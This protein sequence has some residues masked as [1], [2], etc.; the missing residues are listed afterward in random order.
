MNGQRVEVAQIAGA[1]L[2]DRLVSG[3]PLVGALYG[4]SPGALES[5]RAKL[6]EVGVRFDRAARERAAAALRPTSERAAE[7][8]RRFV[9]A[10]GAMV[11]TGQQAGLFTGPMYTIH[12]ALTAV[13]LAEALEEALGVLVLPVFWVASEDH[14]F[15]EVNHSW[16]V[17]PR[18]E[19][20]RSAIRATAPVPVPMSEMRLGEDVEAASGDLVEAIAATDDAR[21]RARALLDPYRPGET[22]AGAFASTLAALLA[23][24]DVCITD[25]ADPALKAASAEVLAREAVAAALHEQLVANRTEAIGALG[26]T[27]P[28]IVVPDAT[29]LF[30]HGRAGRERLHRD[31]AALV[32][33]AAGER[34]GVAELTAAIQADPSRFSPN[35]LLRPV[36]ESVVFP[37]LAYVG[38]PAETGYFAQIGP[39]FEAN[40][41][42]PP[43]AF[44]RFGARVVPA[45]VE[46]TQRALGVSDPDLGLAEH[47]LLEAVARARLPGAVVDALAAL[48]ADLVEHFAALA[49]ASAGIDP[50]LVPA[51]GARR[52]RALLEAARAE[53]KIIRHLKRPAL[54]REVRMVRNHLRPHGVPQERMLTVFQY[55]FGEGDLLR[56]LAA[57]IRIQL[58]A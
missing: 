28:V 45:E 51:L 24:F 17:D 57:A 41:I 4:G 29:N 52:N 35:V 37:T 20:R 11:T 7:R 42:R 32:A 36:V 2:V 3:D 15:A 19:L 12:K 18:G 26:L 9:E 53:R 49:D 34:F 1:P 40:G 48:R 55:L 23:P 31:G 10:G 33:T 22:V 5:Y 43:V 21:L 50:N 6:A 14:D 8:L 39:L 38:G 58:E 13:R 46:A 47:E 44:P 27:A 54:A 30:Y 56:D 25:A 16:A